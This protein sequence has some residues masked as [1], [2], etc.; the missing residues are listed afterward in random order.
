MVGARATPNPR[1]RR[2]SPSTDEEQG[3]G[4]EGLIT[5]QRYNSRAFLENR[6]PPGARPR[7]SSPK[8][9]RLVKKADMRLDPDA[10][11]S[12]GTKHHTNGSSPTTQKNGISASANGHTSPSNGTVSSHQNGFSPSAVTKSSSFYGH[13]REEVTRLLIQGL[14]DL[15]YRSAANRLSQESGY[16]VESPMVGAFR[17]AILEGRWSEAE[18]LLFGVDSE[19]DGGGV[20]I[21]GDW[22]HLGALQLAEGADSDAMKFNIREQK[23]LELLESQDPGKAM[24]VLR[25]EL[26]PLH[27]DRG[28]LDALAR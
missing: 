28:R 27:H 8:R 23:Y 20:S 3:E 9:R 6:E 26:Q 5:E 14:D 25:H 15:G 17:N 19:A 22:H 4:A 2:R 10:P 1:R 21:N 13:D 24:M 18:S 11:S 7:G 12:N 16:E